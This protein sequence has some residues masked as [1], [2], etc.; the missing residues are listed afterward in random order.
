MCWYVGPELVVD[1]LRTSRQN[2]IREGERRLAVKGRSEI[3]IAP[4]WSW[5]SVEEPVSF[6]SIT[7]PPEL[8]P[9][10]ALLNTAI[11]LKSDDPMGCVA[12]GSHLKLKGRLIETTWKCNLEAEV[13]DRWY[14]LRDVKGMQGQFALYGFTGRS[15]TNLMMPGDPDDIE[16][17]PVRFLPDYSITT[18]PS[19][20]IST[21][22]HLYMMPL[23]SEVAFL[24]ISKLKH[25]IDQGQVVIGVNG[26][27]YAPSYYAKISALVLRRIREHDL[28]TQTSLP[29]FERV[30]FTWFFARKPL[31][32]KSSEYNETDIVLI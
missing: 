32:I 29:V 2:T 3:Y 10:V 7:N 16:P 18:F 15:R 4:S 19:E 28:Q 20:V 24:H 25:E 11:L 1:E 14:Q 22:E 30:G 13:S 6:L 23:Q 9:Y 26:A 12:S 8:T 31:A 27:E 21:D 17:E 5:A